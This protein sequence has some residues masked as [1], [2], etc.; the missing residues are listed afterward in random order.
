MRHLTV[1]IFAAASL[2]GPLST[3]ALAQDKAGYFILGGGYTA[4]NAEVRDHLGDG[5]NFTIGGQYNT[6]PVI[7]IEGL[8]S[9]NGLGEKNIKINVSPTPGGSGVPTDF[10]ANMNMQYGTVNVVF[11]KPEGDVKP[12][13]VIGGGIYYRPVQV[14]TPSVGYIPGYCDPF[15]YVCGTYPIEDV[16]GSRGGWDMGFNVGGGIGFRFNEDAEFYV[17]MRY[18][19]VWGPETEP[20]VTPFSTSGPQTV[21]GQ[22]FPITFGLRF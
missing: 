4:P 10:F 8:Y 1:V 6:S 2:V 5:W 11:Q 21:N 18:H 20:T 7:G 22:Y 19:Y 17:E 16:V 15:W 9:F 13:G 14:T 3:S 12:Y